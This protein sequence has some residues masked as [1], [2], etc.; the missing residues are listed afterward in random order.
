MYNSTRIIIENGTSLWPNKNGFKCTKK[1]NENSVLNYPLLFEDFSD[2]IH[3]FVLNEWT[4]KSNHRTLCIN[5]KHTKNF[6]CEKVI[7]DIKQP[8]LRIDLKGEP[9]EHPSIPSYNMV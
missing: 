8:Y 4:P 7:E 2:R 6:D 9:T 5:L 1:H 3:K